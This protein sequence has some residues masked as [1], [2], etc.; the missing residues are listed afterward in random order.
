M[1]NPS[2]RLLHLSVTEIEVHS[3]Q[4]QMAWKNVYLKFY[5]L[6]EPSSQKK[7][8]H[9]L[10]VN[11]QVGFMTVFQLNVSFDL[12]LFSGYVELVLVQTYNCLHKNLH[13]YI[14]I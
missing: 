11:A 8:F 9:F 3:V 14:Y 4:I 10:L 12:V 1:S 7:Y 6:E 2:S 13:I 5:N